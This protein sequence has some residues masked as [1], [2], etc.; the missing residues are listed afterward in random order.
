MAQSLYA[1]MNKQRKEKRERKG[2]NN[3]LSII[4][5]KKNFAQML[6]PH[7]AEKKP[8]R[9]NQNSNT[10]NLQPVQSFSMPRYTEKTG[11]LPDTSSKP[12]W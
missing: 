10:L 4:H 6:E 3:L 9:R 2:I 12:A 5:L 11:G 7:L 8:P 1:H